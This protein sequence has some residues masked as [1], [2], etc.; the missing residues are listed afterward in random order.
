MLPARVLPR[1]GEITGRETMA[2]TNS[3][4]QHAP[5]DELWP[6]ASIADIMS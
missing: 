3:I 6:L 2:G 5:V 1:G 4:G